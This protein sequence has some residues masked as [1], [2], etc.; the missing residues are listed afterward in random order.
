MNNVDLL[1]VL[2]HPPD[3]VPTARPLLEMDNLPIY[4]S[5]GQHVSELQMY[6]FYFSLCA[7]TF[8]TCNFVVFASGAVAHGIIVF[9]KNSTS[10]FM[11]I[12]YKRI[13]LNFGVILF[14]NRDFFFILLNCTLISL[15]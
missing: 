11:S 5:S 12:V 8:F 3:K 10:Y 2:T 9:L 4:C 14:M 15:A 1:V 13:F 6:H 7:C